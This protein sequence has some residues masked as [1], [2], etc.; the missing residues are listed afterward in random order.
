MLNWGQLPSDATVENFDALEEL[1][2]VGYPNGH[3]DP[4]HHT[5]I[6]RNAITATPLALPFG[7]EPT[8]LLDGSVFGGSSGSPVFILN[9]GSWTGHEGLMLGNRIHLVGIVGSTLVRD[10]DIPVQVATA[11]FIKLSKELNLGVAY[12]SKAIAETI[13]HFLTI[14]G[15]P[16]GAGTS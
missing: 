16:T 15:L 11:P 1:V 10:S 8:F 9:W 13:N 4:V 5:P 7:G 14:Q 3:A 6:M 2:F 12:S